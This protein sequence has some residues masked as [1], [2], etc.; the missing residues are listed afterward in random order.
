[1]TSHYSNSDA[2]ENVSNALK[3]PYNYGYENVLPG[4]TAETHHLKE[5]KITI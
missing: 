5:V 4:F 3:F 1:M 2:E